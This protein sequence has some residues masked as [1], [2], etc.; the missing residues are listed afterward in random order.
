MQGIQIAKSIDKEGKKMDNSHFQITHIFKTYIE[1]YS[2][3]S[4]ALL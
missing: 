2:Q 3:N 4:V 1:D